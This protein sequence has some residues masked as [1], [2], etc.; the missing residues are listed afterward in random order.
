MG[1]DGALNLAGDFTRCLLQGTLSRSGGDNAVAKDFRIKCTPAIAGPALRTFQ[2]RTVNT[3]NLF[4][5]E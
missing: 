4:D 5:I 3:C 2:G 1:P